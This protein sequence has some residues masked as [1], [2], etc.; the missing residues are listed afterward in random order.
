MRIG[1]FVSISILILSYGNVIYN[2]F[3][4]SS[5]ELEEYTVLIQCGYKGFSKD[6]QEFKFQIVPSQI[7]CF[8]RDYYDE[9]SKEGEKLFERQ[10]FLAEPGPGEDFNNPHLLSM[11][12]FVL[13]FREFACI[14]KDMT[15][16][17][18]ENYLIAN[19]NVLEW[20]ADRYDHGEYT[21]MSS[22]I[23]HTN[24]KTNC[25]YEYIFSEI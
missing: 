24:N 17:F 16:Q 20:L 14:D 2:I 8:I 21:S 1:I 18:K 4:N 11:T 6:G 7:A 25:D 5:G 19:Y 10:Q 12:S 22:G 9:N 13:R 23:I 3:F 15:E